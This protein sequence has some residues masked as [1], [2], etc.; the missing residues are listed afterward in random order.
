MRRC[1]RVLLAAAVFMLG[2]CTLM[3][4]TAV[5]LPNLDMF[6]EI[7]ANMS[8]DD[9]A[10]AVGYREQKPAPQP[11]TPFLGEAEDHD[12]SRLAEADP[13]IFMYCRGNEHF[14]AG[15]YERALAAYENTLVLKPEH[16]QARFRKGASLHMLGKFDEAVEAYDDHLALKPEDVRAHY[17]KGNSLSALHRWQEAEASYTRAV[18]LDPSFANAYANRAFVLLE[19]G[20][21]TGAQEDAAKARTLDASVDIPDSFE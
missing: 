20:D 10:I 4:G 18:E 15:Q 2:G 11:H 7:S 13:V 5:H 19:M 3:E 14:D 6:D 21:R 9:P 12:M 16:P 17:N 8:G 1:L